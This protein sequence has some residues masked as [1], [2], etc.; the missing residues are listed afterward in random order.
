MSLL[1]FGLPDLVR[2]AVVSFLKFSRLMLQDG[3]LANGRGPP[4]LKDR[5]AGLDFSELPAAV[6][7]VGGEGFATREAPANLLI[8]RF[9]R[10]R[11]S[12]ESGFRFLDR[13]FQLSTFLG[14][15]G[16]LGAG[17]KLKLCS[18]TG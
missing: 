2:G 13:G 9:L 3:N 15:T 12:G 11:D 1:L 6:V 14:E 5:E 8:D 18:S 7:D 4:L 16:N 10:R 17:N